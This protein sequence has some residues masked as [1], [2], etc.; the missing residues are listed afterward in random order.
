MGHHS[1]QNM[2]DVVR[3]VPRRLHNDQHFVWIS[4]GPPGSGKSE[5][6][7]YLAC[8]IQ[9]GPIDVAR[10]IAWRPKDRKGMMQELPRFAVGLDDESSGEG[11]N[12]RRSMSAAN[13]DSGMDLDAC[14]GRN[15]ALGFAAPNRRRLD[16][17]IWDHG[18]W[19]FLHAMD[20]SVKAYEMHEF[21][22]VDDRRRKP[23]LRFKVNR[24][25]FLGDKYP[26]VRED[27]LAA[28]D[29]HM[30]GGTGDEAS[31]RRLLQEKAESLVRRLL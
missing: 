7:V 24:A 15:Q 6:N 14:R 26:E 31:K 21:G 12:K 22:P 17:V 5:F 23:R 19:V 16:D 1:W 11:G 4:L 3:G 27:Y 8:E 28:K 25:P 29:V 2:D 13:V 9:G 10:Q 20:H 30:H 18:M